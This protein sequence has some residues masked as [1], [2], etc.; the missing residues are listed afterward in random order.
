[1]T[2]ED[3][4]EIEAEI[5]AATGAFPPMTAAEKLTPERASLL[6][7][8]VPG[9]RGLRQGSQ[10]VADIAAEPMLQGAG[11]SV[12]DYLQGVEEGIPFS[13]A[14]EKGGAAL[15]AG[16]EMAAGSDRPASD[17]VREYLM[18]KEARQEL[19]GERSPF[20]RGAGLAGGAASALAMPGGGATALGR[21]GTAAGLG[22]AEQAFEGTA[23]FDVERGL[24][25]GALTGGVQAGIESLPIAGRLARIGGM[26]EKISEFAKK[27]YKNFA[28]TLENF[29][30]L[31]AVKAATGRSKRELK[32]IAK[33]RG[34]EKGLTEFGRTLRE[35]GVISPGATI[36]TIRDK[37]AE[38][39]DNVWQHIENLYET[40][41]ATYGKAV[42][43][44]ALADKILEKAAQVEPLPQNQT[45]I[46]RMQ[47][48]A[49][50]VQNKGDMTLRE[51]QDLKNNFIFKMADDRTHALGLDG[52]NQVR[53]AITDQMEET[54]DQVAPEVAKGWRDSMKLYGTF[55]AASG[56]AEDR[57]I[58]N[59]SNRWVSLTDYMTGLT[60]AG[61]AKK[62]DTS[63]LM[64]TLTGMAVALGHK[65]V[66]ERGSSMASISAQKLAEIMKASP[67]KMAPFFG[68]LIQSAKGGPGAFAATHA[69]LLESSPSY[70][71]A[72]G[73]DQQSASD[74]TRNT[75]VPQPPQGGRY[76]DVLNQ[77]NLRGG[78]N[79][80]MANHH[81]LMQTDPS[82]RKSVMGKKP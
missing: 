27:G 3:K 7:V 2:D 14:V 82:Y 62:P 59:L 19:A 28:E 50:Y 43:A 26:S 9:F 34:G 53:E 64:Q 41:D 30:D 71:E 5:A 52:N 63:G 45:L 4:E 56:A 47:D 6:D 8:L 11:E 79:A 23:P 39:S 73:V 57:A 74:K 72:L 66:R 15:Q 18:E 25:G 20:A 42:K 12:A 68:T 1:M 10:L 51:A 44:N 76:K 33:T 54:L 67:E 35:E 75:G 36:Q 65:L 17:I 21:L 78:Q 48:L 37:A 31:R 22:A 32:K 77:A 46:N 60:G 81:I 40:T 61:L 70:R 49:E 16:L 80:V 38:A 29:A 13:G 24:K 69:L 58:A 55:A